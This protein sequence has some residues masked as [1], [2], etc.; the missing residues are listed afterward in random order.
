MRIIAG[1]L[2]GRNI[3]IPKTDLRPTL[4]R[5]KETLFNILQMYIEDSDVLDL[6]AGSGSLGLEAFSRGAKSVVFVDS[7]NESA[8]CISKNCQKCGCDA[9][10]INRDFKQALNQLRGCA[11]DIVFIDP[12]YKSEYYID[13]CRL[14]L[15][16]KLL[17]KDCIVVL[18]HSTGDEMPDS[19]DILTKYRD[20]KM[21]K[22]T[23][24]FF[25][26]KG[27]K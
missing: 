2:K 6:F 13:S 25:T 23:F 19:I 20:K 14:L 8:N 24:S 9:L 17:K 21:G 16:Y 15:E 1:K 26:I 10:I 27:D 4:E 7:D 22:V 3:V 18:E 12:P 11:F 5:T